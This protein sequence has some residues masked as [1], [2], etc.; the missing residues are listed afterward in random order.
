M[1]TLTLDPLG[2]PTL[3]PCPHARPST[4]PQAQ[5]RREVSGTMGLS[6]LPLPVDSG[7]VPL[8]HSN[9]KPSRC[10]AVLSLSETLRVAQQA[11]VPSRASL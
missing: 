10:S 8:L 2:L 7:G 3:R 9:C 6:F 4:G 11:N 5:D 1:R